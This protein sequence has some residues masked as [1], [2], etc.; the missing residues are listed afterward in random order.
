MPRLAPLF[1]LP[2]LAMPAAA[3][4]PPHR[5]VVER[6]MVRMAVHDLPGLLAALPSTK[7]GKLLA[8]PEV[9]AAF[10]TAIANYAATVRLWRDAVDE[11]E[12]ISPA[13]L[14]PQ[15]LAKRA[16]YSTDWRD[17]HSASVCVWLSEATFESRTNVSLEPVAAAEE[18]L[19]KQFAEVVDR[20]GAAYGDVGKPEQMIDGF[21]AR[22]LGQAHGGSWYLHLPGQ[23]VG[24]EGSPEGA[25]HCR[26]LAPP[27]AGFELEIDLAQYMSPAVAFGGPPS[28][29]N[30]FLAFLGIDDETV[31]TWSAALR[32][33]SVRDEIVLSTKEPTGLIG[34]LVHASAP[35]VD[36]RLPEQALLQVRCAFDVRETIA[37]VDHL[38]VAAELP[39]LNELHVAEDLNRAWSGGVTLAITRPGLGALVPRLYATFGIVDEDAA[40]R[41]LERLGRLPGLQPKAA[42]V[43]QRACVHLRIP[44]APA[45]FQ[46]AF[47]RGD[48]VVHFAESMNSLRAQLKAEAIGAPR[49]LEVG[50]AKVPDGK[51][52]PLPNF[53]LR[54]DGPAIHAA[55]HEVWLPLANTFGISFGP[56]KPLMTIAQMP[57]AEV[58]A[59]H[60]GRGRG[61]IRRLPDRLVLAC[62]GVLGGPLLQTFAVALGPV[63]ATRSNA[64]WAWEID[65]VKGRTVAA[66]LRALHDAIEAFRKRTGARPVSL[67]ELA[68]SPDLP[69]R[70]LMLVG[71][72][73]LA[74]PLI[75]N[76]KEIGKTSFR[77]YRDGLKASPQ[78]QEMRVQLVAISPMQWRRHAIAI[79][80]TPVEG[81]GDFASQTIDEIDGTKT[82]SASAESR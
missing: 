65:E 5:F 11:L 82:P 71:N 76:G 39:T 52:A 68:E 58:V 12:A 7:T 74:E 80:G 51:G 78:G 19:A 14:D 73:A 27:P 23:F 55:L 38:L 44:G 21:K 46:P 17:V 13:A 25:G 6:P 10:T 69:D 28:S 64:T 61:A 20:I 53:D 31:L 50:A 63:I 77:Y 40:T 15:L 30:A 57:E 34:A 1:A 81:W 70:G 2:L 4:D 9:T 48:G 75:V 49:V 47:C 43:E 8:E 36:Q 79:D 59:E 72:D 16:I 56:M 24:G 62:E 35:L 45:G 54:F 22:V 29:A 26:P 32:A 42:Q 60:L 66:K 18:R 33:D 67:A 37:A 3:Q 41:L